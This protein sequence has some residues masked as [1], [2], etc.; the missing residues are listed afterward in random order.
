MKR[1]LI[2]HLCW[3]HFENQLIHIF[4]RCWQEQLLAK[5]VMGTPDLTPSFSLVLL[6]PFTIRS[7]SCCAFSR[8]TRA[9]FCRVPGALADTWKRSQ[10]KLWTLSIYNQY[11]NQ[12]YNFFGTRYHLQPWRT[13]VNLV[14]PQNKLRPLTMLH[15]KGEAVSVKCHCSFV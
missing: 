11:Q 7:R 1:T 5:S 12:S 13:T 2:F 8:N 15:C 10:A 4:V 14:Q 6:V 3:S 9:N